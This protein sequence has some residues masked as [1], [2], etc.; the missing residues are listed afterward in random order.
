MPCRSPAAWVR[1]YAPSMD[2]RLMSA[3]VPALAAAPRA[4][5][6]GLL[7]SLAVAAAPAHADG[8]GLERLNSVQLRSY[9]EGLQSYEFFAHTMAGREGLIDTS[10]KTATTG[11]L[12]RKLI[13]AKETA[14]VCYDLTVRNTRN[15]IL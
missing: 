10:V 11:Y 3:F 8:Q 6:L 12:Q 9:F 2:G 4:L 5:S 7:L 15:N 14:R 13:K 1:P